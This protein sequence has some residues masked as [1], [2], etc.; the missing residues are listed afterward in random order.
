MDIDQKKLEQFYGRKEKGGE[1]TWSPHGLKALRGELLKLGMVSLRKSAWLDKLPKRK[2]ALSVVQMS[3]QQA[4]VHDAAL[5]DAL[6]Q[7]ET[8]SK[9]DPLLAK[10][11]AD[12]SLDN[13]WEAPPALMRRLEVLQGV[14]DYP[15]EMAKMIEG[16]LKI[17]GGG[18]QGDAERDEAVAALQKFSPAARNAMLSLKG[19]VSPK[20]QDVY[21]KAAAHL[22]DPKNGKFIVFCQRKAAARHILEHMPADLKQHAMYFDASKLG[23]LDQFTGNDTGPRLLVAVDASIKEGVNMQRANGLYRY[24]HHLTPGNQDQSYARID[25]FGQDKPVSIHL[26]IV[27]GGMDVAKYARL[28]SKGWVNQQVVSD[29]ESDKSTPIFKLSLKNLKEKRDASILNDYQELPEEIRKWQ[30]GENK[31]YKA[32]FGEQPYDLSSGKQLP[33]GKAA[34][35]GAYHQAKVK[36]AWD[37][38]IRPLGDFDPVD[39]VEYTAAAVAKAWRYRQPNHVGADHSDIGVKI[40]NLPD[41]KLPAVQRIVQQGIKAKESPDLIARR[42]RHSVNSGGHSGDSR[43]WRRVAVTEVNNAR[44]RGSLDHIIDRYGPGAL[45]YRQTN[46]CCPRCCH[47]FGRYVRRAWRAGSVPDKLKG[48]V[49]PNCRCSAWAL[50]NPMKRSSMRKAE[51]AAMPMGMVVRF[52]Q[53][54]L[55]PV[56]SITTGFGSTAPL[57]S[58]TGRAVMRSVLARCPLVVVEPG[59]RSAL[60]RIGHGRPKGQVVSMMDPLACRGVVYYAVKP[61]GRLSTL[62]AKTRDDYL[63]AMM[64]VM[65]VVASMPELWQQGEAYRPLTD[66][67]GYKSLTDWWAEMPVGQPA[68]ALLDAQPSGARSARDLVRHWNKRMLASDSLAKGE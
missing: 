24:D 44:A 25:R 8:E 67:L 40:T 36:K 22:K 28:C 17:V 1:A 5:H 31:K 47:A 57:D 13:S 60:A 42:L 30:G 61:E 39:I 43:D 51:H 50:L 59:E 45:V 63:L 32:K 14:T 54:G 41:E 6:E 18:G 37:G 48:A 11:L 12:D 58:I 10:A 62:G 16:N 55:P 26:G 2:D 65:P 52:Q 20:A 46:K 66:F 53:P 56:F 3:P 34:A 35:G 23:E 33:G 21:K 15:D 27:D 19:M 49:H 9:T 64:Q 4:R 68:E 38:V 29:F 7:L